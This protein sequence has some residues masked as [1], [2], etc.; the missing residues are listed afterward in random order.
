MKHTRTGGDKPRIKRQ[1][2]ERRAA[3][4][5]ANLRKRKAQA[6]VRSDGEAA[7]RDG[8]PGR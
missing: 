8:T 4:L 6:R 3:A 5:R 7:P 1:R 2:D